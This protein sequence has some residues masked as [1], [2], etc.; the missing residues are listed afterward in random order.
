MTRGTSMLVHAT[1]LAVSGRGVLIFGA[2]GAGKSDLALRLITTPLVYDGKPVETR[3]IADDQ[4]LIERIGDRLFASP[5]ATIAGKLEVRG[6]GILPF[7][8]VPRAEVDLAVV[9]GAAAEI[10]RLPEPR[11]VYPL[12]G[13][14]LALVRVEGSAPSAP[15]KLV[16]AAMTLPKK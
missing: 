12:L 9:L 14:D 3:L 7:P 16:L 10:D 1:A 11:Q 8:F 2:S 5:P 15:S 13:L 6:L 4:V